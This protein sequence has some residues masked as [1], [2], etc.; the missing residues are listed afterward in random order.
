MNFKVNDKVIVITG[1]DKGKV[2]KILKVLREKNK[3]IVEGINIIKKSQKPNGVSTGG[4]VEKE[5][6]IHI[7]NV[8]HI[9]PKTNK[10]TRIGKTFDKD[11]NKYRVSKKTNEKIA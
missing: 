5:A 10:R 2:G 7:S 3:V 11:G 4:I 8:M 9:D 1:K 6:P